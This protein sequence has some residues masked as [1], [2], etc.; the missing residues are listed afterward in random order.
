MYQ[1]EIAS[2][3]SLVSQDHSYRKFHKIWSFKH[4]EN[5]LKKIEKDNPYKGFG[6]MCLY[7]CI[8]LQFMEDNSDREHER[9][10]QENIA[11]KWFC[12]F[13]LSEPT[14]HY[15]VFSKARKRIGTKVLAEIF[16]DLRAQLKSHGLISETFSFIDAS[17]LI[18]KSQLWKERDKAIK[19]KYWYG[20]KKHVSVDMQSGLINKVAVTPANKTDAQG[21]RHVCP[22]QGAIYAD[23]A[24]CTKAARKT[25]AQKG[26]HLAAIKKHNMKE[27]NKDLDRWHSKIRSPYERVFSQQNK[28]VRYCGVAK[29]QFSA[30]MDAI[31]FNLKRLAVL[32]I[33]DLCLF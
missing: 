26:C 2:L 23:K 8:L 11:A 22:D 3:D 6:I 30:F 33:P 14:P 5:V 9:F 29:N 24:Y 18:A 19:E 16:A 17:S 4:A 13:G 20:F 15:S 31:C 10:L 12:G 28:R 32:E 1:I 27:K 25:A 21:M 7:K